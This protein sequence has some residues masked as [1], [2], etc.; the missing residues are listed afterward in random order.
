MIAPKPYIMFELC[1]EVNPKFAILTV[2]YDVP[3]YYRYS[4]HLRVIECPNKRTFF[5]TDKGCAYDF[6]FL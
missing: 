1:F 5:G 2:G 3:Y 6:W 4:S